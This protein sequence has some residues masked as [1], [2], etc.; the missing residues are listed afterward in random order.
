M[1]TMKAI[2]V[3]AYGGPDVLKYED[4]AA[5][6][7]GPGEAVVN[8]A[9]AGVNFIDIYFRTGLNRTAPLPFTLGQEGAGTVTS[10]AEGVNEVKAGDRVAYAMTLGSYAEYAMVPAW[11]LVKLPDDIDFKTGAAIMLQGM[12]AH[13]LTHSTFPLKA[14]DKAVVHAGAGGMGL[15]LTQVAKKLGAT[16]YATVGSEAK[17]ELSRAAGADEVIVYTKQDFEA[18]VKRLTGGRGVEVVY[19]SVGVSTFE[20]S[21]NCLRPRGYMVLYGQSSG[22]VPALDPAVLV[23]KG[24]LFLTRPTLTHYSASRDEILSRTSDLFTWLGRGELRFKVDHVYPLA[25]A[26]RAHEE[27]AARRTTGKIVLIP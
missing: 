16:V 24:S 21:L 1:P 8:I 4:T 5:P 20:K 23:A 7:A 27:L 6:Q 9:A 14:G 12:T 17:A 2:R 19:D 3:H 25:E 10:T 11:K 22:P 26:A 15:L 18:E 13:Y